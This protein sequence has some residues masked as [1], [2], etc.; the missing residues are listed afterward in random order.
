MHRLCRPNRLNIVLIVVMCSIL[1][2]GS[3]STLVRRVNA[4]STAT[5]NDPRYISP[6]RIFY[7]SCLLNGIGPAID[8]R[9]FR[10]VDPY[11]G[12]ASTI[13]VGTWVIRTLDET[14]ATIPP[15]A[16]GRVLITWRGKEWWITGTA[17]KQSNADGTTDCDGFITPIPSPTAYQSPVPT[18]TRVVALVVTSSAIPPTIPPIPPTPRATLDPALPTYDLGRFDGL[19]IQSVFGQFAPAAVGSYRI[20]DNGTLDIVPQ[21]LENCVDTARSTEL[22]CYLPQNP[23]DPGGGAPVYSPV[24]GC[25]FRLTQQPFT[26][27]VRPNCE[28]GVVFQTKDGGPFRGQRE[29]LL[30]HLDPDTTK[31]IS[32]GGSKVTAGQ[33]LASLC[34]VTTKAA[35]NIRNDLPPYL[36]MQVRFTTDSDLFPA[37]N[38]EVLGVIAS[39]N[40]LFDGFQY[41][42]GNPTANPNPIHGCP[43]LKQ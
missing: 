18:P 36:A 20:Y 15:D 6:D 14:G 25:A 5:P 3:W 23:R 11:T 28:R 38:D 42:P 29:I 10:I 39:P 31:G 22:S 7:V 32:S 27:I 9:P 35:C 19:N 8:L 17:L 34:I 24:T 21:Y 30:T 16:Q 40:C 43:K 1:F 12:N 37:A 33:Y 41:S 2:A 26:V 4:Q 13:P